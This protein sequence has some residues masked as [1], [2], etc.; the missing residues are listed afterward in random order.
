MKKAQGSII[1][2]LVLVLIVVVLVYVYPLGGGPK[3]Q[4]YIDKIKK[5]SCPD[6]QTNITCDYGVDIFTDDRG[7]VQTNCKVAEQ[8]D[9]LSELTA[10]QVFFVDVGQGDGI[11][12]ETPA[13]KH[14]VIDAGVGFAMTDFLAFRGI[15]KIDWL[16]QTHPDSDHIGGMD[17]VFEDFVVLNYM[18]PNITCNTATCEILLG[19][20]PKEP[21]LK[22]HIAGS[23]F[24][25]SDLDLQWDVLSPNIGLLF[26]DRNDNS[27]V[28][29]LDYNDVE[30][31]FT[32]DCGEDCEDMLI[33]LDKDVSADIL[34]VGHH[35]SK[36]STS[37]TFLA[38]VNPAFAILSYGSNNQYGHPD[39]E[40]IDRL[41]ANDIKMIR[42]ASVG[43][44]EVRTDGTKVE[45]YCEN[46]ENCFA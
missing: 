45:W 31:L 36:T 6:V 3:A 25:F 17:E 46:T 42:T 18:K 28:I 41:V 44:I 23:G 27:I 12:I 29:R 11:Y 9:Q 40:V 19:Y 38:Q 4:E 30:F 5:V 1:A 21:R 43:T 2:V 15:Q 26:D 35:G 37:P 39:Q 13:D 14:I 8:E 24:I 34:K 22:T 32:G 10:L 20:P 7:C 16:I 33:R